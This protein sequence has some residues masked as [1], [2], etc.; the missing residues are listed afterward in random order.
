MGIEEK[1]FERYGRTVPAGKVIFRDSEPGRDM[2]IIQR[3]KVKITKRVGKID[4]TLAV[5]KKGDFFGEM[6]ILND[7]PRSATA[8]AEAECDLLVIDRKTFEAMVNGKPEIALRII[9]K[10]AARLQE[11]DHQIENLLI[12][13]NTAKVVNYIAR[14]LPDGN[15]GADGVDLGVGT[16][17]VADI[18]GLSGE[19]VSA[20]VTKLVKAHM[21]GVHAG[22]L[23]VTDP[24]Q[25]Q[26]FVKYL[27]M[28]DKFGE[29]I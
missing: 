29:L 6:S 22:R 23:V 20:V 11:A 24:G 3:G 1:L 25:L 9:K 18:I 26:R 19:Q 28:R 4:K 10:L 17:D 13:D 21:V 27:D 7:R 8:V 2:F 14:L 15:K 16:D 5:L 12:K